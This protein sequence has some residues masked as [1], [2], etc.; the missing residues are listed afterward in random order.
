MQTTEAKTSTKNPPPSPVSFRPPSFEVD[1]PAGYKYL[2]EHGYV[3]FKNVLTPEEVSKGKDL[4]WDFLE[5]LKKSSIQRKDPT[6]WDQGWPDPFN[7]G[8]LVG[9]GVGQSPFL[10]Y[11]RA[12]PNVQKIY[13]TIWNTEQVATSFDG[14]GIHRPFEY[15][16][17]WKTGT[18]WFHIDQNGKYKPDRICVQGLVNFYDSGEDDGGLVVVPDSI[19]IFK[20]IFKERD[21]KSER[22]YVTVHKNDEKGIWKN[23]AAHLQPI[24]VVAN[25]G[26]M[27]LWDSRT[28]HCNSPAATSRKIP[29]DGGILEP[30]RL[31]AYVCM[32]PMKRLT[33]GVKEKRR[34]AYL[35]GE[36]TS[37]WPEECDSTGRA[38]RGSYEPIQLTEAQ[39]ALIPM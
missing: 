5:G 38:N 36:T 27:L 11:V 17:K 30:R 19:K 31:V 22:D 34:K 33:E 3:V 9:D 24:K 7:K 39:K 23:E 10:W 15:N 37:H 35:S 4:A 25:A 13:K 28:I 29:E 12:N 20:D 2:E 26:D 32:V 1:D 8:I 18:G 14:F 6:T 21:F 16:P